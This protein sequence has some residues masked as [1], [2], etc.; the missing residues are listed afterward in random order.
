MDKLLNLITEYNYN[1][2]IIYYIKQSTKDQI[3]YNDSDNYDTLQYIYESLIEYL[4]NTYYD[5]I[6]ID[7][8]NN[9]ILFIF[10]DKKYVISYIKFYYKCIYWTL[11]IYNL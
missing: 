6:I 2:D 3:C 4:D 9:S 7:Y 1:Y 8:N 5:I 11:S 10:E